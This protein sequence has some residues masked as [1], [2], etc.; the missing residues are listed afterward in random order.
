MGGPKCRSA[1]VRKISPPS[2]FDPW[3]VQAVASR[4]T[5]YT[6]KLHSEGILFYLT[7]RMTLHSDVRVTS[8]RAALAAIDTSRG[9]HDLF[10]SIAI[11]IRLL[12]AIFKE[13]AGSMTSRLVNSTCLV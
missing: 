3:T 13:V 8:G 4:Y 9:L 5:D 12:L 6:T 10:Q 7:T 1:Q 11:N 2:G